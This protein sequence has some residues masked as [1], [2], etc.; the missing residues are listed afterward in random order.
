MGGVWLYARGF[1]H[2]FDDQGGVLAAEAE[3]VGEGAGEGLLSGLVGDVIEVAIG[4]RGLVVDGGGN[5]IVV[6]AQDGG[7]QL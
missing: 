6:H 4:V 5:E 2:L 1:L 3:G 7:N